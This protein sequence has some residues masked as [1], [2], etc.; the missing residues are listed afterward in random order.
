MCSDFH[1]EGEESHGDPVMQDFQHSTHNISVLR[2]KDT[3]DL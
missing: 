1:K 3:A 2:T